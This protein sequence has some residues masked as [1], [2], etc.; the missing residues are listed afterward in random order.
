MTQE[1]KIKDL[2]KMVEA[3]QADG[4]ELCAE[5][6]HWKKVAAGLKG[7][8]RQLANRVE[9]FRQLDLEGDELYEKSIA[10]IDR[11]KSII[12]EKDTT[13]AGLESQINEMLKT[14]REQSKRIE[15]LKSD[16]GVAEANLEYYK[17]LPWWKKIF[18][19]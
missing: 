10:E 5:L 16:V 11:L 4:F 17:S 19:K 7:H 13:I 1:E 14:M 9:H 12:E 18:K 6:A 3:M 15:C 8:N 2:E